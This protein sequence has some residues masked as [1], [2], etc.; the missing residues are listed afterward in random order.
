MWPDSET[1]LDFL[2]YS[3]VAELIAELIGDPNLLP[4]S[5]GVFG[6]WGTGKSS[7]LRLVELELTNSPQKYLIVRFDAWLYQDFDDARAAL[8]G[9]ISSAIADNVPENLKDKAVGLLRR[10]NKLRLLGLL[11]EGG[12]AA[13][14]VPAFGTIAKGVESVG[15]LLGGKAETSDINA[16]Q[17]A[18]KA[19][20]SQTSGLIRTREGDGGPPAEIDAFRA[21]F[22]EILTQL[23]KTLVVF[24]DNLDRCLPSNAIHTLEA[25]RL[26][27]FM[28][29]TAFVVAADEDMIR[30][31]VAQHFHNPSQR[32]V[33]DYLDKLI[34]IPIRVPK[35]GIQEVRAYLF[36]LLCSRTAASATTIER[37]RTYLVEK[38]RCS[39]SKDGEFSVTD[40]L[41]FIDRSDDE[42]LVP[43]FE[44][45]DRI[46]PT[47]ALSPGVSGNP[48]IVKRM[49]NV[50]RMRTLVARRRSIP[51]DEAMITKL[52]LF[53][54]CTNSEATEELHNLINAAADGKPSLLATLERAKPGAPAPN[55]PA[56]WDK[57]SSFLVEWAKLP[58]LLSG[59]D[60]RPAV[61]L[62]RETVPLRISTTATSAPVVSAIQTLCKVSS[63]S[64][65]AA[66]SALDALGPEDLLQVM[67]G[68]VDGMRKNANWERAR[69]D[70][71]GAVITAGRSEEA[72]TQLSRFIRSLQLPKMPGWMATMLKNKS[73][74]QQ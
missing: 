25:I 63:I 68:I 43:L 21:E 20:S 52:A 49:L 42:D 1:D 74:W 45:A 34:Q 66:K 31:A 64:S 17:D 59:V 2:N 60:L 57:H 73:W 61:Y 28:P 58:P 7:I 47:L 18:A 23:E 53:E 50:V 70:F 38:L 24:V 62:A 67:D 37:L 29:R 30:H 36:L 10:V 3:E 39:W 32:H 6:G 46:A 51:L 4:L 41:S 55:L 48:R 9:V 71:R 13:L 26:F 69:S 56:T 65:P 15:S 11:V 27:L 8:M 33:A 14:G 44:L 12:V 16:V 54:R 72:A 19:I 5:L 22:G 40:V 35:V